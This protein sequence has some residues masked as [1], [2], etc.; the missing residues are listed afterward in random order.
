MTANVLVM[1]LS[2]GSGGWVA[3]HGG[4][5]PGVLYVRFRLVGER[6][7][8][9]ELYLDG[10]GSEAVIDA[11]DLRH[12]PLQLI[13]S[14]VNDDP[15]M[16]LFGM[17]ATNV[18]DLSALRAHFGAG[19]LQTSSVEREFRLSHGPVEGLTDDF[20]RDVARAYRAAQARD[21]RPNKSIAEQT[22]Y[23]LKTA[24]RWVYTARQRGIMP[25]GEKGRVV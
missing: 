15:G 7:K 1:K 21:E 22:G 4:S 5:L 24:Q 16:L 17:H 25:R 2:F 14:V 18:P 3:V 19:D 8:P 20:L 9:M 23:P 12:L 10:S 6:V 13:E 11:S